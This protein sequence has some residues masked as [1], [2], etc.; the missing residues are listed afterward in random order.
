VYGVRS[1]RVYCR[2]SCPSRR[3]TRSQVRFFD[4]AGDAERAGFRP[5]KRCRPGQPAASDPWVAKTRQACAYLAHA[6]G[7]ITLG[8]LARR[9]G[10]SRYHLQRNFKRLVGVTPRTFGDAC[11][12]GRIKG[13]LRAGEPITAAIYEAGYGSPARFYEKAAMRLGMTPSH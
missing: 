2:P 7:R 9:L 1:T 4:A 8:D 11:R 12:L 6:D 10:G 5:C 13:R 3:P